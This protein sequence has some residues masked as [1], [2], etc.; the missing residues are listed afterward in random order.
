MI[1]LDIG[2]HVGYYT[3]LLSKLVGNDG[4]VVAFEPHPV[5]Y[6]TLQK[7]VHK[8][9]NVITVQAAVANKEGTTILYDC[10]PESGGAS[11]HHD[12][13]KRNWYK[14]LCGSEVSPRMQ[15]GLPVHSYTVRTIR[16]DT[17][18]AQAQIEQVDFIKMDIEGAE[19]SALQGMKETLQSSQ[20]LTMI[21]EFNPMALR[22]FGIKPEKAFEKL[23]ECGF[24]KVMVIE[25]N[26]RLS[27]LDKNDAVVLT[28]LT[29]ELSRV[30]LI[31]VKGI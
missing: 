17:Y 12:K 30:N 1:V 28:Q 10:L 4:S 8:L 2:A 5:T 16:V 18:L 11:F 7:N 29:K 9:S 25:N 31:C 3:K 13:C 23:R 21:M 22:S 14:K 27:D 24:Q 19:M 26:G 20:Y 6:R 15:D